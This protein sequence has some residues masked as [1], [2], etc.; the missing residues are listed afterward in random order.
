MARRRTQ[1]HGTRRGRL[2]EAPAARAAIVG[3]GYLAAL[4]AER[5]QVVADHRLVGVRRL[6]DGLAAVDAGHG[7]AA[8]GTVII[9][10]NNEIIAVGHGR[11]LVR[12][13][14]DAAAS[15]FRHVDLVCQR[16][17]FR[18]EHVIVVNRAI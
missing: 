12:E 11:A 2:D 6:D 4:G 7:A 3:Q 5:R 13:V 16:I 15:F 1:D 8:T 18:I 17:V 9:G 10:G 14:D